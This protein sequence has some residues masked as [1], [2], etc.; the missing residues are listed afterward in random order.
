MIDERIRNWDSASWAA[1]NASGAPREWTPKAQIRNVTATTNVNPLDGWVRA[2]AT[3]GA[4]TLNLETAVGCDGRIHWFNKTDSSSNAVTLDP[5]GTETIGGESTL[6]LATQ[7]DAVII[8]SNGNNWDVMAVS[9]TTTDGGEVG[10]GTGGDTVGGIAVP[11]GQCQLTRNSATELI[12][13]RYRGKYVTFPSGVTVEVPSAGV[14]LSNS[15]LSADTLYYI[16]A[17][18]SDDSE[19]TSLE[20]STTAYDFDS[21]Y[22]IAKK[23]GLGNETRAFQG[24]IRTN[25][26]SQ[27]VDTN[28]QR[29]VRTWHNDKGVPFAGAAVGGGTSS[30]TYAAQT[31]VGAS[32][33]GVELL[34]Y[35][36]EWIDAS[37]VGHHRNS[38]TGA[39]CTMQMYQNGAST[40]FG[41]E[42]ANT[43]GV[44]NDIHAFHC[45][46][47]GT[48]GVGGYNFINGYAKVG[49]GAMTTT[50]SQI[51]GHTRGGG[52]G[53]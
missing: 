53:I 31:S 30:T 16:Y 13:S 41:I 45:H 20:A 1:E 50:N 49:S 51:V 34:L 32:T 19:V 6:D 39:L 8:C 5:A 38:T 9:G 37:W 26:S 7:N 46:H 44:A 11:V 28:P 4:I 10:G 48:T 43:S 15:G 18:T 22:G 24:M 25:G 29:L 42:V 21:T 40:P 47:V 12:L 23:Q 35:G 2:D 33:G 17:V 36:N 52:D 3:S 27:F 14:T